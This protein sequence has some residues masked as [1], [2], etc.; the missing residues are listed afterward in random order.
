MSIRSIERNDT[1]YYTATTANDTSGNNFDSLVFRLRQMVFLYLYE[2]GV[3]TLRVYALDTNYYDWVKVGG[4]GSAT[5]ETAR[6]SGGIGVFGSGVGDS[7]RV[8]IR[9]DTAGRGTAR[10]ETSESGAQKAEVP[11]ST[12]PNRSSPDARGRWPAPGV[13]RD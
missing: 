7:V 2:P 12:N 11:G 4:F 10:S 9:A 1:F 5:G 8:Y 3:H 13:R 6:L